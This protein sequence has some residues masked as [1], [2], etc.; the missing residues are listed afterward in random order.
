LPPPEGAPEDVTPKEAPVT[1]LRGLPKAGVNLIYWLLGMI[2]TF[3]VLMVVWSAVS[4]FEYSRWLHSQ[5]TPLQAEDVAA[6][7]REQGAFR[8]FW[9]GIFQQ[10]LSTVLVPAL[11]AV[12][13]FTFTIRALAK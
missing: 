7:I 11:S 9:R 1:E 2:A 5:H 10:V 6:V 12:L 3:V 4:E 13:A 8:E